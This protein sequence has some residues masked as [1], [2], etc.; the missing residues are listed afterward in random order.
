MPENS[1]SAAPPS[2]VKDCIVPIG[3]GGGYFA[4]FV[5]RMHNDLLH[6]NASQCLIV[7]TAALI[8]LA[9]IYRRHL[10]MRPNC[11]WPRRVESPALIAP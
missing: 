2:I 3:M 8:I 4:Y 1:D 11:Q 7:L 10:H 6:A 9:I 5:S